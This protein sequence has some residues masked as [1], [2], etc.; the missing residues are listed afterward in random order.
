M[1]LEDNHYIF[2]LREACLLQPEWN[3]HQLLAL[4][5]EIALAYDAATLEQYLKA[6]GDLLELARAGSLDR[7]ANL[8]RIAAK[9]DDPWLSSAA[10]IEYLHAFKGEDHPGIYA[11][12]LKGQQSAAPLREK[13]I[14]ICTS[15]ARLFQCLLRVHTSHLDRDSNWHVVQ[16]CFESLRSIDPAFRERTWIHQPRYRLRLPWTSNTPHDWLDE[17]WPATEHSSPSLPEDLGDDLEYARSRWISTL[18]NGPVVGHK[19][20]PLALAEAPCF[21][22][23]YLE[24]QAIWEDPVLARHA[25]QTKQ[26]IQSATTTIAREGISEDR[27]L[28][29]QIEASWNSLLLSTLFAPFCAIAAHGCWQDSKSREA[30]AGAF[31][32]VHSLTGYGPKAISKMP[33]V[34]RHLEGNFWPGLDRGETAMGALYG[35]A[36]FDLL[37]QALA[38]QKISSQ[39]QFEDFM[40]APEFTPERAYI[41]HWGKNLELSSF[42]L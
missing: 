6:S 8:A 22:D 40:P 13:S 24:R 23:I 1:V 10:G 30:M 20:K 38:W 26:S 18:K 29:F 41:Q 15:I 33:L 16:T 25:A 28:N 21:A 32:C 5:H 11:A 42:G 3:C 35:E 4:D 31:Q 39:V 19:A 17:L 27:S 12:V 2:R 14:A 9:Y 37:Q 36:G 7:A 34:T